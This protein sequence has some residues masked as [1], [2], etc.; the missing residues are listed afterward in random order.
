MLSGLY[1][2]GDL[3]VNTKVLQ[4]MPPE[5]VQPLYD[6]CEALMKK[7]REKEVIE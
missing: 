2:N 1:E 6:F 5:E 7:L 4:N 3:I